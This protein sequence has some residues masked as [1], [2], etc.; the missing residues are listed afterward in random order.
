MTIG[1]GVFADCES[2][3]TIFLPNIAID[4]DEDAFISCNTLT[5]EFI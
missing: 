5:F 2:L 4:M 3:D 1:E